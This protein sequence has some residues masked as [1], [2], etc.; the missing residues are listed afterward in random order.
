MSL[1]TAEAVIELGL[2]VG[3]EV[4]CIVKATNVMVEIPSAKESRA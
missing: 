3:D 4:V 2:R 1:L